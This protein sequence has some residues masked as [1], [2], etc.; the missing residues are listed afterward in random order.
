MKP[1]PTEITKEIQ[2]FSF[3]KHFD[4]NLILQI[5]TLL[6]VFEFQPGEI[7]L[8][9]GQRNTKLYF[10]RSGSAEVLLS[11]ESVA[12]LTNPGDVIGEMSV[13][14]E[15]PVA[16]TIRATSTLSCFVLDSENFKHVPQKERDHFLALL[17]KL[18]SAVLSERL[19]KTNEKARLFEIVNREV[20]QA[21]LNLEKIGQKNVLVV[22]SDKKQLM[23]AKLAVGGTG[24]NLDATSQTTEAEALLK[25]KKYDVIIADE[26]HLEFLKRLHEEKNPSSLVLVTSKDVATNFDTYKKGQFVDTVISIDSTDRAFTIRSILTTLTKVLTQDLF[27][28]EKYLSWGVDIQSRSIQSSLDR[29]KLRGEMVEYF[30][31]LGI[32]TTFL[33]RCNTVTEELLMNAI[34]DAPIDKQGQSLYNNLSRKTP[35]NLEPKHH[36]TLRYGSDGVFLAVSVTD[37]FGA[38]T[39]DVIFKYLETCYHGK[40]ESVESEKGGAGRGLHQIIENSD[41]TIFNVRAGIK[42][43][44][45]C[46]FYIESF[47]KE[48]TPSFHYFFA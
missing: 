19:T 3:F 17:Y 35:V 5:S 12:T 8:S 38:L 23:L 36:G 27:G 47:R 43:E 40:P 21:Q 37:P 25:N 28:F 18:F 4:P 39:K 42:T 31:K 33:E 15:G 13:A 7:V 48:G 9:E 6:E 34:Y 22:E 45:I 29:P 26:K 2:K 20:H 14:T 30:T 44:V 32:R 10:I 16:T 41:L 24:V 11:G 46:L 1:H